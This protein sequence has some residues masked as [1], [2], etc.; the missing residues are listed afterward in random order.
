MKISQQLA[1]PFLCSDE[2][3][4]FTGIIFSD[5]SYPPRLIGYNNNAMKVLGAGRNVTGTISYPY[6]TEAAYSCPLGYGFQ[7]Y[8]WNKTYRTKCYGWLEW[9]NRPPQLRCSPL[10]KYED[11]LVG[12]PTEISK[13]YNLL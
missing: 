2:P 1:S 11:R 10:R 3:W 7:D 6:G 13:P 5:C 8:S 12:R 4:Q 9:S